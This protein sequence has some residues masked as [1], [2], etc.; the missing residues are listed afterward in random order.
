MALVAM[1]LNLH[2]PGRERLVMAFAGIPNGDYSHRNL[3][4]DER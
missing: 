4:Y 2:N 1:I 3:S